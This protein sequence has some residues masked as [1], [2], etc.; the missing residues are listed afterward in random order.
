LPIFDDY[1]SGCACACSLDIAA[2]IKNMREPPLVFKGVWFDII[3]IIIILA[4]FRKIQDYVIKEEW[5]ED[6]K[7]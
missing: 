5:F 3:I 6:L 1:F 7:Y 2:K 4:A